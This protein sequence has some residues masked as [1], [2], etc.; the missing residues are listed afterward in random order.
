MRGLYQFVWGFLGSLAVEIVDANEF[1]QA[2][3]I[4]LPERY[5]LLAYWLV[6]IGLAMTGGVLAVAC[7][8]QTPH[9]GLAV[10]AAAPLIIRALRS[11]GGPGSEGRVAKVVRIRADKPRRT[12]RVTDETLR[13]PAA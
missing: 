1:F 5:K 4:T 9:A 10:G 11:R 7:S 6:R 2:K 3:E 13:R 12:P 8:A